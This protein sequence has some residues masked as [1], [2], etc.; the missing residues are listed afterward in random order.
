MIKNFIGEYNIPDDI[1]DG[2]V[3]LFE[4]NKHLHKR[5]TVST[6]KGESVNEAEKAST[7]MSF[8]EFNHEIIH[9]YHWHLQNAL[10]SY[11]EEYPEVKGIARFFPSAFN[12]QKYEPGEGYFKWHSERNISNYNRCFVYMTYLNTVDDGGETEFKYQD[13]KISPKRGKTII[14]PADWTHVHRGITSPTETKYILTGW[15]LSDIY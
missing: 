6:S 9:H 5:G 10:N 14:W 8:Y 12:I 3:T 15:Y 1:C 7:D 13:L 11:I 4:E 2:L